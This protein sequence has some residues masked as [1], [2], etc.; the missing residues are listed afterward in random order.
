MLPFP[1]NL[2]G[3]LCVSLRLSRVTPKVLGRKTVCVLMEGLLSM[4]SSLKYSGQ[5][6]CVVFS[7]QSRNC[8][9]RGE[10]LLS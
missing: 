3:I 7:G 8:P 5:E 4:T 2:S 6:L 1:T 9:S 10:R